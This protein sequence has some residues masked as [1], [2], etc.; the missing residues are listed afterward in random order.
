[1]D[2]S[3]KVTTAVDAMTVSLGTWPDEPL[4][5]QETDVDSLL[6]W[7][8]EHRA[9][10]VTI[11]TDRQ[12]Y[13]EVDGTLYPI[14]RRALDS[15]DL[16]NI[17]HKIYGPDALAKL[18]S[19]I[20]LDLSFEVRPDRNRRYRFRTNITAIL[21]RGRDSVQITMRSLPNL[22]PTML[23]LGIEQGIIE[24]W[25]PRQGL[26][27]VT[28]PT[29]S[30]KTTLLAA[31]CRMLIERPQG[32]GKMLTYEA[33][34]EYVY[35][36]ITGPRS[37]VAQTE[38]PRHLPNFAAGVRNALRRKP[39]IIMVGEARDR[40]TMSAAIEAGQTGHLVFSTLH[41]TGVAATIRRIISVFEPAERTE[42][43]YAMMETLRMVVTQALV[44]KVGGGRL[45][46]REYLV[47]DDNVREL[48]L[49]IPIERW[50]A[51]TQRFL[52]RYGQ[53]MER[54]ANEA[55]KAG[56]IDRR[57]Y[58][59]L[60]KGFSG[61]DVV[62]STSPDAGPDTDELDLDALHDFDFDL[63]DKP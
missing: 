1:M 14:T 4:R 17:L 43:A 44:P 38:V 50:T 6:L 16:A 37:L 31:G 53:T 5:I 20:D 11:Q 23:D 29:G 10:D 48:L 32:C 46:L 41:T 7:C 49:D 42:R 57:T 54:S 34:I 63:D 61:E 51:E 8:A 30:G 58:L 62:M 28:G 2:D 13:I 24:N 3:A 52:V 19:G 40:E 22:P 45:G 60:I 25:S 39:N 55:F 26:V 36:A 12:V 21:S 15:A 27:L 56:L 33:P 18:A 59:L 9:T 47:F 35:D